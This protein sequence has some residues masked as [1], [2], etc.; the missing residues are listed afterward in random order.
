M[1][2]GNILTIQSDPKNLATGRRFIE[3]HARQAGFDDMTVSQIVLAVDEALANI[4]RHSYGMKPDGEIE[5][6]IKS[7]KED[8]TV[9]VRDY[10]KPCDPAKIKPRPLDEIRPGGL[11]THFMRTVMDEVK[12][13]CKNPGTELVM[14]KKRASPPRSPT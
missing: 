5:F 4:I 8:F 1:S 11:G 2:E 6:K 7:S 3:R 9:S 10:G 12:Y 13:L 14:V